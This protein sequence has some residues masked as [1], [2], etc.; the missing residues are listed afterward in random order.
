MP[1]RSTAGYAL[2]F[3]VLMWRYVRHIEALAQNI[4]FP[5]VIDAADPTLLV[6]A[7]K[8]RRATMR[9]AMIHH[10]DPAR[11]VTKCD[12]LLAEQHQAKG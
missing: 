10:S 6:A 12:Q 1:A 3:E 8:Q 2:V 11:A 4:E 5:A 9:A 7:K